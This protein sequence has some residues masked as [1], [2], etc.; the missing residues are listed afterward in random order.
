MQPNIRKISPKKYFRMMK[1]GKQVNASRFYKDTWEIKPLI[2][3]YTYNGF[4]YFREKT[5][6]T[7]FSVVEKKIPIEL[8]NASFA[9]IVYVDA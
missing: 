4:L 9:N 8:C 1:W 5:N 3:A 2:G 7:N 6:E